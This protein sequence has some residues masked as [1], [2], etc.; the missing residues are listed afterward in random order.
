MIEIQVK[1]QKL[2]K[3]EN[4]K[5]SMSWTRNMMTKRISMAEKWQKPEQIAK[6]WRKKGQKKE[7]HVNKSVKINKDEDRNEKYYEWKDKNE[8]RNE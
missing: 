5:K 7:K 6:I 4:D 2:Q 3:D 8:N 1:C